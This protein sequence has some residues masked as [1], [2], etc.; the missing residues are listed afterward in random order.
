M[1]S[2][3]ELTDHKAYVLS[4]KIGISLLTTGWPKSKLPFSKGYN[5]KT[6][7]FWPYFGFINMGS[8]VLCFR[9]ITFRKEQF[10]FGSPCTLIIDTFGIGFWIIRQLLPIIKVGN[11]ILHLQKLFFKGISSESFQKVDDSEMWKGISFLWPRLEL[12]ISSKIC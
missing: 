12:M 6:M 1:E 11:V 2:L 4:A 7:H 10:W 5:S 8:E 3:L 9:V